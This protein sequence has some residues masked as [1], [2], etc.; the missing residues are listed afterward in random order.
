[1]SNLHIQT[2]NPTQRL[3]TKFSPVFPAHDQYLELVIVGTEG[4]G[5]SSII[6]QYLS[7]RFTEEYVP[8]V[9]DHFYKTFLVPNEEGGNRHVTL[10]INECG[11]K[12]EYK[13]LQNQSIADGNAF[14]IVC[15][16]LDDP[17][18]CEQFIDNVIE[19]INQRSIGNNQR[20]TNHSL[21]EQ[22]PIVI[23]VNKSDIL[24]SQEKYKDVLDQNDILTA[25]SIPVRVE[26]K[27]KQYKL[28]FVC[29]T[30][31]ES[32][33]VRDIFDVHLLKEILK[34]QRSD[35]SSLLQ[36]N[37][38][39]RDSNSVADY[40]AQ[41]KQLARENKVEEL[42]HLLQ[43]SVPS[44]ECVKKLFF[45][46]I[47]H[48][49]GALLKEL[50]SYNKK[51]Q[52]VREQLGR[53]E[54]MIDE[55]S[56]FK[57]NLI[58]FALMENNRQAYKILK[59][60]GLRLKASKLPQQQNLLLI[61]LQSLES[62]DQ[63]NE[64]DEETGMATIV[65][66]DNYSH[67]R[68]VFLS[69]LAMEILSEQEKELA[70]YVNAPCIIENEVRYP[71]HYA[72][73]LRSYIIADWLIRHGAQVD[74]KD[75]SGRT[76]LHRAVESG[77][78]KL[79]RLFLDNKAD[80]SLVVK[81][82]SNPSVTKTIEYLLCEDCP[83]E[84]RKRMIAT[85]NIGQS[86]LEWKTVEFSDS[87]PKEAI[88]DKS[89][90]ETHVSFYGNY[91]NVQLHTAKLNNISYVTGL[92]Y[93]FVLGKTD[94]DNT[95]VVEKKP[96]VNEQLK[97]QE[98]SLVFHS[99]S[100]NGVAQCNFNALGEVDVVKPLPEELSVFVGGPPLVGKSTLLMNYVQGIYVEQHLD[101]FEELYVKE[102]KVNDQIISLNLLDMAAHNE[103]YLDER[104]HNSNAFVLVCSADQKSSLQA[105]NELI[106]EIKFIKRKE[107]SAIPIVIVQNKS[108]IGQNDKSVETVAKEIGVP[109][110]LVSSKNISE[111]NTLFND[112]LIREIVKKQSPLAHRF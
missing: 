40:E 75:F 101:S 27:A 4:S 20:T 89:P 93:A 35:P 70:V 78:V 21:I 97:A 79:A 14:I 58:L 72:V 103:E 41:L 69:D 39:S 99:K 73:D 42:V 16:V 83:V 50:V 105:I 52:A 65:D 29:C 94:D 85:L 43:T 9:T 110:C 3:D 62:G 84:W 25:Q 17:D 6:H 57:A 19:Q 32:N 98:F 53:I 102:L 7:N 47:L 106:D 112:V 45:I 28:P 48:E 31:R 26:A 8:T 34:K 54:M 33:Q 13:Q 60:E 100:T 71:L 76:P 2:N 24:E 23:V 96:V 15:S 49:D 88:A 44:E 30:A 5:K 104:I 46:S 92:K 86:N 63:G 91:I 61:I 51:H 87:V 109:Y 90:L 18:L 55:E 80:V 64:E 77:Q 81:S 108:D 67:E 12:S 37:K 74:V 36:V 95:L 68:D 66:H 22:T 82:E 11:G 111:L 56:H 107:V 38:L 10:N 59:K 1:M